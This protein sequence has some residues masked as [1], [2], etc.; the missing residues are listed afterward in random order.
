MDVHLLRCLKLQSFQ[1]FHGQL[2]PVGV[3]HTQAG[4]L[5]GFPEHL[6]VQVLVHRGRLEGLG[7]RREDCSQSNAQ[8]QRHAKPDPAEPGRRDP[9][10]P[11]RTSPGPAD[12]LPSATP[13]TATEASCSQHMPPLPSP[14]PSL[15]APTSRAGGRGGPQYKMSPS[16]GS[17]LPPHSLQST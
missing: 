17:P 15:A 16:P 1:G 8:S 3:S 11:A 4:D 7:S 6:P 5:V 12:G 2:A 9:Q 14:P 13:F 10:H